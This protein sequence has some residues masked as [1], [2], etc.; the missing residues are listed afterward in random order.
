MSIRPD[1]A[2]DLARQLD[3]LAGLAN[4]DDLRTEELPT[5]RLLLRGGGTL[6]GHVLAI[7][8]G[9]R[10]LL[11]DSGGS[12]LTTLM[13]S[14]V[15]G[16]V[17]DTGPATDT[18]FGTPS[19]RSEDAPTKLQLKRRVK[20]IAEKTSARLS[21]ELVIDVP[22]DDLPTGD[23]ARSDL[24]SLFDQLDATLAELTGDELG[25][26]A[27]SPITSVS[28]RKASTVGV[29]TADGTLVVSIRSQA[30]RV[31]GPTEFLGQVEAAL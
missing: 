27:L 25:V 11:G 6:A 4:D 5:A 10:V 15:I 28:F 16:M 2:P 8:A 17:L 20:A 12:Q 22:W 7:E 18:L 19:R 24:S 26:E 13:L 9:D 31:L 14:E 1:S 3:H 30:D 23:D 21:S 29:S